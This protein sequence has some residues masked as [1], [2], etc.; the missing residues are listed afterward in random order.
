[1]NTTRYRKIITT[2]QPDTGAT[3]AQR[4]FSSA[5][6]QPTLTSRNFLE[7]PTA[8][9]KRIH[10]APAV[11]HQSPRISAVNK[12][13]SP[14]LPTNI[15]LLPSSSTPLHKGG[16]PSHDL[17]STFVGNQYRPETKTSNSCSNII[18]ITPPSN[19]NTIPRRSG[20]QA[21]PLAEE[22]T[23]AM[24]GPQDPESGTSAKAPSSAIRSRYAH[25][26]NTIFYRGMGEC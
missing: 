7:T 8:N 6:P 19:S 24:T 5:S 26:A 25:V 13:S 23:T 4:R 10:S 1:M 16:L 9:N 2:Y 20:Y 12:R 18:A 22:E 21:P 14:D 17:K 11:N 3:T 15:P